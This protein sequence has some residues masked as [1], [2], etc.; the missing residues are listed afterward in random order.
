MYFKTKKEMIELFKDF[1]EAIENTIEIADKCNLEIETT[2]KMPQFDIP[3]ESKAKNLDEYLEELTYQG[4]H[5]RYPEITDEIKKRADYE[6]SVINQMGFP[7]YFLIVRDFIQAAKDR[8]IRVGPGRGSAVG[9]IVSYALD[10]TAL[11]PLPYKLLFERFLNPERVS[12]PDIDI[13]FA[14]NKRDKVIEY[15]KKKYGEKSVA[16]IITFGKLSSKA[17]LKDVGRVLGIPHGEIN[18]ITS[19]IPSSM[20]KVMPLKDAVNLPELKHLKK[21]DNAKFS[22]LINFSLTLEGKNRHSGVHAAGVVIAP[23]DVSDYVPV[24]KPAREMKN[25]VIEILSQ[26]SMKYLEKA[27]LLK[28]DFLGLR[29]LSII[30]N[31]LAMIEENHGVKVDIDNVDLKDEKTYQLLSEGHTLA[32]FQFESPGMQEYLK[33]LNPNTLDELV[34]MNALYR[35]GPMSNIP[36]YIDRKYGRKNI[37][38]LHP[39]MEKSLEDTYGIIV[40]Q[41]QVMQLVQD[42]A[43]FTL[44][45]ADVLRRVMGKK[46]IEEM[47]K[48]KP[49]FIEGCKK[50]GIDAKTADKI[51]HLIET[52]ANYGFNKSHA[53]AYA[54]IAFQTAWLK[55]HYPEEF[56]AA[57]MTAEINSQDSKEKITHL[58]EEAEKFGIK[59]LPPNINTSNAHFTSEKGK[60]YFGLAAIKN[61]GEHAVEDIVKSRD[62]K[63]YKSFF[64]FISRANGKS[65]NRKTLEALICSGVFDTLG[66]GFRSQLFET[67]DA[68]LDYSKAFN[69]NKESSMDS[70]FG[71]DAAS[72]LK[73]PVLA[74]VEPWSDKYTLEKEKEFLGFY[75][76]GHPLNNYRIY[77][78][79]LY[80][81][82]L[83]IDKSKLKNND[84]IVV[85]GIITNIRNSYDKKQNPIAFVTIEDFNAK[86]ECVFWS[87]NF[88][89]YTD[90]L[91]L[92]NVV[93]LS[94]KVNPKRDPLNIIVD[95]ID[96]IEKAVQKKVKGYN[97]WFDLN[98]VSMNQITN[99]FKLCNS[100]YDKNILRF[101]IS[102]KNNN[103][104]KLYIADDINISIDPDTINQVVE[105]FGKDKVR[106]INS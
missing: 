33:Q 29:T 51:F 89:K 67:I 30:D 35:P 39:L 87:E 80:T 41:E 48:Q 95:E 83:N 76:S 2:R 73:K 45:G 32:V 94:G 17:V 52:F 20:G 44:G 93:M 65:V 22:E 10:I 34:A 71:G 69:E 16:Q 24:F 105:I 8:G 19:K 97:I 53:L 72:S 104:K 12:M 7:G 31:A 86:A 62:N 18:E 11:D 36:E 58:I 92:D 61:V 103:E 106:L 54:Y 9:S 102:N 13:D 100:L 14:D 43:G 68:A 78:E 28:M 50:N 46:N 40:Y 81:T 91:I 25:Q 38:Y 79:S 90:L 56:L 47:A 88:K 42:L 57:N 64:E 101:N 96:L 4:L 63:P 82:P 1:P 99:L 37:E 6:L 5:K 85:C 59:V 70:L 49:I 26:Y 23:G 55:V 75:V 3:P 27:G 84:N 15:V 74:D 21:N 98:D 60:I 77:L 66:D